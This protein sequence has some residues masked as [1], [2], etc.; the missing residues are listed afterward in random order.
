MGSGMGGK[1][2]PGMPAAPDYQGLALQQ[3]QLDHPDVSTPYGTW[4]WGGPTYDGDPSTNVGVAPGGVSDPSHWEPWFN[5]GAGGAPGA[6]G[7]VGG[8]GN[9]GLP[10]DTSQSKMT[11]PDA[12]AGGGPARDTATFTFSPEQQGLYD[13]G[14]DISGAMNQAALDRLGAGISGQ[15]VEDALYGRYTSR[16]DPQF[17]QQEDQ[18]RTRMYNMGLREGDAAFDQQM[19]NFGMTRNDAYENAM[20]QAIAGGDQSAMQQT[21]II[22]MLRGGNTPQVPGA[23]PNVG[24]GADVMGAAAAQSAYNAQNNP[25]AMIAQYAPLIA[26]LSDVRLKEDVHY[27]DIEAIPGVR[28]A[29]WKW[30]DGGHCF[31]VI[32]QDVQKVRPDLVIQGDDGYLRVNY[33]GILGG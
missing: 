21:S 25:Y 19:G 20:R 15:S 13:Q 10:Y 33:A 27:F 23:P 9:Y 12:A 3:A 14:I 24:P 6:G 16:L 7:G 8:P 31:G 5:S 17:A 28:W 32:A 4:S 1:G 22:N 2:L 26:M 30:K 18:L 29:K 11:N